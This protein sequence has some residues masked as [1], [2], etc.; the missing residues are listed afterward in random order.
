MSHY[1]S[2]K[3][4][5]K[6]DHR[7]NWKFIVNSDLTFETYDEDYPRK[8]PIPYNNFEIFVIKP[9]GS[10]VMVHKISYSK[11]VGSIF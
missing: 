8:K 1:E 2:A 7:L 5:R 10:L 9:S 11:M 4:G 6:V 3:I